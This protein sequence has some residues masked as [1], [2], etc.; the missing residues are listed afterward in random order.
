MKS[1][2][3]GCSGCLR[4]LPIRY[5]SLC[6]V[7][8]NDALL[9]PDE[10]GL[11]A[12]PL[13]DILDRVSDDLP[14]KEIALLK[15]AANG[16]EEEVLQGIC[17]RWWPRIRNVVVRTPLKA[18]AERV[19]G[20]LLLR[21][22]RIV[23]ATVDVSRYMLPKADDEVKGEV[24]GRGEGPPPPPPGELHGVRWE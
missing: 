2:G 4:C 3:G 24:R 8:V 18:V 1:G 21:K 16:S 19:R 7:W 12:E 5:S 13:S 14:A 23:E 22:L 6:A 9:A 20:T 10:E 15:V 17:D 11:Q